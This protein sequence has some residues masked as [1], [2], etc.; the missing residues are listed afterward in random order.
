[1]PLHQITTS[2]KKTGAH[3]FNANWIRHTTINVYHKIFPYLV[4]EPCKDNWKLCHCFSSHCLPAGFALHHMLSNF[5]WKLYP[6]HE[7]LRDSLYGFYAGF[8]RRQ[9]DIPTGAEESHRPGKEPQDKKPDNRPKNIHVFFPF[10]TGLYS[11]TVKTKKEILRSLHVKNGLKHYN[12]GLKARRFRRCSHVSVFVLE[13]GI[14]F[15]Q[16]GLPSTCIRRKLVFTKTLSRVE[17]F[18]NAVLLYQPV[19]WMKT[20]VFE[21]LLSTSRC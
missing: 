5:E 11:V 21:N 20:K 1:M 15:L 14:Y 2:V 3:S 6:F 16:F 17:I 8:K 7:Q 10:F 13:T 18:E 9:T 12:V 19:Q 4:F